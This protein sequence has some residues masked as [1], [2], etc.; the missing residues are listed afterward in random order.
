VAIAEL[1]AEVV[2]AFRD[3]RTIAV[4]WSKELAKVCRDRLKV[5]IARATKLAKVDPAPDAEA[6]YRALTAIPSSGDSKPRGSKLSESVKVDNKVLFTIALKGGR[7]TL[8][9][10]QIKEAQLPELY[11]D[12]K[13][14]AHKW[15]KDKGRASS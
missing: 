15:L 13:A 7:F 9:P 11:E 5:V 12:L 3:P 2:A 8:N 6:V 10:K 14:Y 4:R 1:P